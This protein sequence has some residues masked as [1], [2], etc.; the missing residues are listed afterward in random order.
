ME[1]KFCDKCGNPTLKRVTYKV[2]GVTGTTQVFLKRNYTY[3]LRGTIAPIP[4]PRGGRQT[5][6]PVLR[7]DQKEYQ[8]A[9]HHQQRLE[10]KA[11]AAAADL[12]SVDD[13]LAY[14]FGSTSL[15]GAPPPIRSGSDRWILKRRS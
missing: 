15:K 12:D 14:V 6:V 4:L 9:L 11:S 2:D 7:E 1:R 5:G 8:R 10:R 3:N 13:R